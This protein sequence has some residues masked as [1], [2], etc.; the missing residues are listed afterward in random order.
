MQPSRGL[1]TKKIVPS[2]LLLLAALAASAQVQTGLYSYGSFDSPGPDSIDRGSL[3]VHLSI[4]VVNKQGRGM[5]F[6]YQLV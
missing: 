6:Q 5:P 1:V 4:P 3:N 2:I